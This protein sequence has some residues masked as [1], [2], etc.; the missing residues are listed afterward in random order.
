LI[1]RR[2]L[3]RGGILSCL[4]PAVA[5]V[6][7]T[8]ARGDERR[9]RIKSCLVLF[10]AGGVSQTDT[11]DMKPMAA[12]V[13]RG[14]FQPISTN[15]PGM[16]PRENPVH[17]GDLAATIYDAFGIDARATITDAAGRPHRLAEGEPIHGIW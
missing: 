3:L 1:G 13:V 7:A 2:E 10:Q 12:D 15:V 8:R 11:F 17:V 9:G 14:E 4:L 5:N 16:Y 6:L